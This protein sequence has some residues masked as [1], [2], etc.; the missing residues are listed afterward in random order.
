[1][2][3]NQKRDDQPYVPD[4]IEYSA[5]NFGNTTPSPYYVPVL[6]GLLVVFALGALV[7]VALSGGSQ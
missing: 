4:G 2:K 7:L 6:V 5:F 1:M 3:S